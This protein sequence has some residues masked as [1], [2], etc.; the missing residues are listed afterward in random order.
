MCVCVCVPTS[1]TLF[2]YYALLFYWQVFNCLVDSSRIDQVA[3]CKDKEK[4]EQLLITTNEKGK[5]DLKGI[6]KNVICLPHGAYHSSGIVAFVCGCG[7]CFSH[8]LRPGSRR[9]QVTRGRLKTD[10]SP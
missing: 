9:A 10:S 7:S 1:L 2:I 5:K 6:L 4:S 8:L 3:L